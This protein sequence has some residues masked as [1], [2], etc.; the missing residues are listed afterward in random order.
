MASIHRGADD[1]SD[2]VFV[3]AN[4]FW[5][6][7]QLPINKYLHLIQ[8]NGNFMVPG[9]F[10]SILVFVEMGVSNSVSNAILHVEP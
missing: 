6:F 8:S 4:V 9:V 10:V 3:A 2:I 7:S 5:S 1:T